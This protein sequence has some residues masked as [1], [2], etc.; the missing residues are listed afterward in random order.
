MVAVVSVVAV[1]IG[2]LLS[3]LVTPV[4]IVPLHSE[5]ALKRAGDHLLWLFNV[6][7]GNSSH[8]VIHAV[9]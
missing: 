8:T 5:H 6:D 9:L 1:S 4:A 2:S 7:T 3:L